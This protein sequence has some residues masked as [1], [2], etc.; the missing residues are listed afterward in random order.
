M[1]LFFAYLGTKLTLTSLCFNCSEMW[2]MVLGEG[3]WWMWAFTGIKQ[4][5]QLPKPHTHAPRVPCHLR[6]TNTIC[7][8]VV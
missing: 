8:S 7:L 1:T 3:I 2:N 4:I 6:H 5:S